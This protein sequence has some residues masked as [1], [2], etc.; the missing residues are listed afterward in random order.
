MNGGRFKNIDDLGRA[1][2]EKT[3]SNILITQDEQGMTL[4]GS[5]GSDYFSSKS[6]K[7]VRS[8]IGAGDTVVATVAVALALGL[9]LR[10][11][12][13][14]SNVA[15]GIVVGKPETATVSRDEIREF[16]E[17]Q[18][19][20]VKTISEMAHLAKILRREGKSIALTTGCFDILHSG[21]LNLFN[22]AKQIGDVLIVGA[23]TDDSIRKIKGPGRPI[24]G[25]QYRLFNLAS[26]INVDYVTSFSELE[27]SAIIKKIRP[28]F[29]IK[30]GD[31]RGKRIPE[32]K[33]VRSCGGRIVFI[34]IKTPIST[35]A[36]VKKLHES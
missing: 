2:V 23:N 21:H 5:G 19:A 7:R 27:P 36:I 4:F 35:T 1:L 24:I 30:G 33:A 16:F 6:P 12:A 15:G 22:E 11:A 10:S 9:D 26:L 8:V 29:F 25:E 14:L 32:E 17:P 3:N 18:S 28:D 34:D 31:W 13:L 20:K